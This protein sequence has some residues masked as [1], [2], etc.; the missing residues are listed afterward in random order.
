MSA[1]PMSRM[2]SFELRWYSHGGGPEET[3]LADFGMSPTEFFRELHT[4]LE[5]DPPTPLQPKLVET[6]KA[7][8]RRR[9]WAGS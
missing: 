4:N 8:A 2:V 5:L 3:I 1:A 9:L 7:V 6:M